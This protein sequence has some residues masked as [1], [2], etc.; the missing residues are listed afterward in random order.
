VI[1][2]NKNDE[3][4]AQLAANILSNHTQPKL[5]FRGASAK[6]HGHVEGCG[7]RAPMVRFHNPA[8]RESIH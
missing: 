1:W 6:I 5:L 3:P 2:K 4:F 8:C 7:S